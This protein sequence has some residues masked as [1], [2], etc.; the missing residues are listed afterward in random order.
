MKV[1]QNKVFFMAFSFFL[2]FSL[3]IVAQA[4]ESSAE[5]GRLSILAGLGISGANGD[6]PSEFDATTEFSFNPGLRLRL[7]NFP[8][9]AVFMLFDVGYLETGFYGE[10]GPTD[11]Y[12]INTYEYLNFNFIIGGQADQFYFGGGFYYG[13][14]LDA[15][16]YREYIDD[17]VD[18]DA[19]SDFGLVAEIGFDLASFLSLGVQ[20]RYGLTSIGT[21]VDIKNWGILGT[22]G[23]HF[24]R[25]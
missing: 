9:Q 4:G 8:A 1:T 16:S 13:I 7:N 21:S 15:Y 17:T 20:G 23:I 12:F 2:I 14:G 10:V 22:I 11:T 25:F 19:N 5:K 6:Y 18:L 24:L 3:S